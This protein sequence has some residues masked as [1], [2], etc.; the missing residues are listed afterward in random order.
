MSGAN[1][2]SYDA[3]FLF[4]TFYNDHSRDDGR[5]HCFINADLLRTNLDSNELGADLGWVR[6]AGQS[7]T[8]RQRLSGQ[9][10][11]SLDFNTSYYWV[12]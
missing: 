7:Y 3:N 10:S 12:G 1:A 2:L 5:D 11:E 9:L 4:L 8:G 6:T